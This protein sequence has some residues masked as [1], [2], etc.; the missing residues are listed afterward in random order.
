MAEY[1][2]GV[3]FRIPPLASWQNSNRGESQILPTESYS[4][5]CDMMFEAFGFMQERTLQCRNLSQLP[6]GDCFGGLP[7]L[8]IFS[9]SSYFPKY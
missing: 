7:V 9:N 1:E 5:R 2:L 4:Y 3:K 8:L 6:S